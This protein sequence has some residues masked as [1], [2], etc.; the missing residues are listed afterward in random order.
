MY[1]R[2]NQAGQVMPSEDTVLYPDDRL[3]VLASISG[4]RRIEQHQLA[5][6]T[7]GIEVQ[8]ALTADARFDGASEI[9]RITGLNLGLARQFMAQIPGQLPQPL[10]HHQALRLVRHLH[11][12]QVKAQMI[13]TP[14]SPSSEFVG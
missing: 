2:P 13:A 5:T 12:V 1:Q 14:A 9:A 6:K 4:L 10:Y 11:R 3:V 8:A 7:W